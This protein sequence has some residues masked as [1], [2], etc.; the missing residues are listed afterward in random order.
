M[1]AGGIAEAL[2]LAPAGRGI[3]RGP[4]PI[5]G[6]S[7]RFKLSEG[8]GGRPLTWCFGGCEPSAL[9]AELRRRGLLPERELTDDERRARAE[10][11]RLEREACAFRQV[12]ELLVD[13]LL[14]QM[15]A[16][17]PGRADLVS[18]RRRLRENPAAE[19]D[20]WRAD[21]PALVEALLHAAR[22]HEERL[23]RRVAAVVDRA[24]LEAAD[25][26]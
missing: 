7:R 20:A 22:R 12:V 24:R 5:C 3:W 16:R 13:L 15:D 10:A 9:L 1:T 8:A 14:E 21:H 18:L 6:G 11:R 2:R 4:C 26:R 25:E 17:D 23:R 19:L